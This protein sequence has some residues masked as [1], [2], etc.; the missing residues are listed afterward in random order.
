[1]KSGRITKLLALFLC[2][3]M[4]VSLL[5]I[6]S[7]AA[8]ED[9]VPE[10]GGEWTVGSV[11]DDGEEPYAVAAEDDTIL[12][13]ADWNELYPFGTFAFGNHQAD[14][15]EPGATTP[16]RCEIPQSL[17]IPVYR[18][19]G[20]V[21]RVTARIRF[22][23]AVTKDVNGEEDVFDYAASGSTD[24]LIEVE[25]PNPIA[26]YQPLGIPDA[27][28]NI[29]A[30]DL[31]VTLAEH[32]DVVLETDEIR[33]ILSEASQAD[34]Y[35]WQ[36]ND[37]S[38]W[39]D[40]TDAEEA[41]LPVLWSDLWDFETDEWTG[42]DFRCIYEKD[43]ALFSTTSLLGEVYESPYVD[44][45]PIPA[46]LVIPEERTYSALTFADEYDGCDFELTFADGETVKYIRVT[47]LDDEI[48]ELPEIGLFTITGC[49]GGTLTDTCNTL[50]LM[51]SD[52]DAK[53]P[54][55]LGFAAETVA[56]DRAEGVAR[57]KVVRTGGKSYTVT[58]HY[59]TENGTA[60]AGID[61]AATEGDLAFAG[62]IDEIEILVPLITNFE[63]EDKTFSLA[64]SDVRGGGTEK[65]CTL[66]TE[67]TEVTL[68]GSATETDDEGA[69][70]NLATVLTGDHG[71]DVS[72]RVNRSEDA[73]IQVEQEAEIL[74]SVVMPD[75]TVAEATLVLPQQTRLHQVPGY[76]KFTRQQILDVE[77]TMDHGAD[78]NYFWRDWDDILG[79]AHLAYGSGLDS[80]RS[81]TQPISW[82][83]D[84]DSGTSGINFEVGWG[85]RSYGTHSDIDSTG[86]QE[87]GGSGGGYMVTKVDTNYRGQV[88]SKWTD[89]YAPGDY[90]D[91]LLITFGWARPGVRTTSWIE[92]DCHRYLR[93]EIKVTVGNWSETQRLNVDTSTDKA[94]TIADSWQAYCRVKGYGNWEKDWASRYNHEYRYSSPEGPSLGFGDSFKIEFDFQFYNTWTH[95]LAKYYNKALTE[96]DMKQ[97]FD[98]RNVSGHRRVFGKTGS[99][100]IT[101]K[102]Y[103]AND[104]N[105]SVQNDYVQ[106]DETSELYSRLAPVLSIVPEQGGVD[107][108]GNIYVGTKLKID[109]TNIKA[110]FTIP[111]DG[112]FI[113]NENHQIVGKLEADSRQG[114]VWY[115]TMIWNGI[116]DSDLNKDYSLCVYYNRMQNIE[117][118]M[119]HAISP[120]STDVAGD[121]NRAWNAFLENTVT[122]HKTEITKVDGKLT[123][124]TVDQTWGPDQGASF[125]VDGA[126]YTLSNI[127]NIQTVCF[128]QDPDDV[129]VYDG[130]GYAGNAEIPLAKG[131][132]TSNTLLF[133]FYSSEFLNT[134][135]IMEIFI[136][137]VEVYYDQ[138]GDGVIRGTMSDDNMFILDVDD[139]GQPLDTFVGEV[140]GDYPDSYF[141]PVL[142]DQGV[143]HEHFFKVFLRMSPRSLGVPSGYTGD[144]KAQLL[145]AF[146]TAITDASE[147]A[148]LT[149]EQR[150]YRYIRGFDTD[151]LPMFGEAVYAM[152]TIDIPLG[153]DVGTI[154][155]DSVSNGIFNEDGELIDTNTVDVFTWEPDFRGNLL[156]SFDSPTPILDTRNATGGEVPL[157]GENPELNADGTFA[158][159]AEGLQ[160]LNG[161]LG[162]FTDRTT[163]AI[164]VQEQAKPSRSAD[165]ADAITGFSDLNPESMTIGEVRSI[166][167]ADNMTTLTSAGDPGETQGMSP[168]TSED[169]KDFKQDFGTKL[170]SLEFGIG[171]KATL[172]MDG[173][174]VG[175]AV[176]LPM[177]KNGSS[178]TFGG[179]TEETMADGAQKT[180]WTDG[181]GNL[182]EQYT[183]TTNNNEEVTATVVTANDPSDPT[184]RTKTITTETKGTDGKTHYR[185]E[186][187][188]Q[189][190]DANGN[191]V[192]TGKT[193]SDTKPQ[194]SRGEKFK[195]DTGIDTLESFCTACAT[196]DVGELSKF[197][198]GQMK[199]DTYNAAKNGRGA[200][201]NRSVSFTVQF[202]IMF[203]YNPIDDC[204][205]FKSAGL[206]GVLG[207]NFSL[208]MRFTP[209]PLAYLYMKVGVSFKL[210]L[211]L[212]CYRIA[213]YG[214]AIK[215]EDFV[216]GNYNTLAA[217]GGEAVFK[218]DMRD[219]YAKE[220]GF[221]FN[222]NGKVIME[223]YDNAALTG[224][225]LNSGALSGNGGN[226]ETLLKAYDKEVYIKLKQIN[227]AS[228]AEI[229]NIRPITG[230]DSKVRFNG[231]TLE[232]SLSIEVGIGLGIEV[233]KIEA[234]LRFNT[235]IAFTMGG[236]LEETDSYEG[237]YI[238]SFKGS[239]AIGLNI[240]LVFIDYTLDALAFGFE[241]KQHGTR[242]YF[243]WHISCTA[244]NGNEELWATDAYTS[245]DGHTLDGEPVPPNGINIFKDNPDIH[246]F[247]KNGDPVD[248]SDKAPTNQGW[249][250]RTGV[251]AWRWSGGDFLGEVPQN[252]DLAEADES[253]VFIKFTPE[254][255]KIKLYFSGS[256]QVF[257]GESDTT[258]T[259]YTS[260][261]AT[262]DNCDCEVKVVLKEGAKLDRYHLVDGT[263]IN[264]AVEGTRNVSRSLVHISESKDVSLSQTILTPEPDSRAITPTGTEDFELSGYNTTGDARR[265]VGGLTT[266]YDYLLV[267]AGEENYILYPYQ[268][269]GVPQLVLSKLVMTDSFAEGTG[270]VHPITGGTDPAYL[271]LD[272]DSCSDL[273]FDAVG[274]EDSIRVVWVTANSSGEAGYSVK[275]RDIPLTPDETLPATVTLSTG[276][277]P[278][279]LPAA[280][281]TGAVWV[282]ASG[283]GA[284]VNNLLKA[285]LRA[286]ND[287]MTDE[288]FEHPN[289]VSDPDI[290]VKA[291]QWATMSSL[292]AFNGDESVL[293]AR[294]GDTVIEDTITDEHVTNLETV[295][296]GDQ[297][298]I[299]YSTT[300]VVYFDTTQDVPV[301]VGPDGMDKAT[302][303]S[304]IHRLYLRKADED[305]FSDPVCIETVVDHDGCDQD[306]LDSARLKDGIYANG[307][308]K[309]AQADPYFANLRFVSAELN[310]TG[311]QTIAFFEM[312]GNTWLL[313]EADMNTLLSGGSGN[314]TITPVFSETT[315]TDVA[316]GSD[317]KNLAIVY[318]A[319]VDNSLSN[320]IFISWWDKNVESWGNPTI[321][322]MRGLQI[323]EDRI[324][325]DMTPEEA[326]K[327]YFGEIETEGGHTGSNKKLT[328]S[329]LQMSKATI[330]HD[331]KT[332]DQLII[333]TTGA[334]SEYMERTFHMSNGDDYTTKVPNPDVD[335]ALGFY[336]IGFG[337][338]EQAIGEGD[339]DF[340]EHDF[341][342]GSKLKGEVSFRNTGT[343]AIRA[344]DANPMTIRL[345]VTA[346]IENSPAQEIAQW[347]LSKSIPSGRQT[348]LYFEG[349]PL[350]HNLR[351]GAAFYLE[352]TEDG[353]FTENYQ[354]TIYD[355]FTLQSKPE[356]SFSTFDLKLTN[357]KNG[358]A[359]FALNAAVVNNGS[360]DA[361]D[362]FIQFSY[363]SGEV[364]TFGNRIYYPIDITG[365][366][367]ET[368]V[369]TPV[370]F[371]SVQDDFEN[372]IYHLCGS[373]G[374]RIDSG[375]YRTVTGD[376]CVPIECFVNKEDI[377]G[378]HI[379]A[380]IYC[381][382]DTPNYQYGVYGSDHADY[383]DLNN[384]HE[385][386]IK[387][388][389]LFSVPGQIAT[390]LGTTLIL[391]V[392]FEA[393]DSQPDLLLTEIS[394]G[395]PDWSPRM[396][397]CYYDPVRKV[398]VAAPNSTAQ[399]MLEA[400]RVP[401]GI[402]QL[403]DMSTNTIE[404]ITYRIDSMAQG[405]NI[406]RDDASFTFYDANGEATNLYTEASENTG[407][408]FLDKGVAVGWTG[409]EPG[410]IP[411]NHDLCLANQEGAFFTF[412]T[413]ADTMTF[414]FMGQITVE[415]SLF[416]TSTLTTSPA[417]IE[418]NNPTGAFHTL[419][420]TAKA[421]TKI[422]RYVATYQ[423]NPV[424]D[425][426]PD[427]PQVLWNRSFPDVAS[428]PE[429]SSVPMT[430]YII[431]KS[432]ILSVSFD[433]QPLSETTTPALVKL[434]DKLWY[435]DYT[436]TGNGLHKV[437]VTDIAGNSGESHVAAEWFNS[438]ISTGAN[439]DAPEFNRSHVKLTDPDGDQIEMNKPIN[440][441]PWLVSAYEPR[442]D[443]QS[444]VLPYTDGEFPDTPL[445]KDDG[446][447]WLIAEDGCYQLRV[448]REDGTWA[449]VIVSID[450]VDLI[451]PEL[452]AKFSVDEIKIMAVD[453]K[454]IASVTVNR[455]PLPTSGSA[456]MGI[457]PV[458]F[459][460]DYTVAVSDA[461]GN[462][463]KQVVHAE[464]PLTVKNVETE[465]LCPNGEIS[466]NVTVKRSDIVG[467]RF[468]EAYSVP[469]ENIYDARYEVVLA[470]E[471][472]TEAPTDGWTAVNDACTLTVGEGAYELF[473]RNSLGQIAKKETALRLY[474]PMSWGTPTYDWVETETGY[475]VTATSICELDAT[476]VTTETVEATGDVLYEA[477]CETDGSYIYTANFENALFTTQKKYVPIPA[478]GHEWGEPSYTWTPYE[479]GYF[480]D[481]VSTCLHDPT[482]HETE[483]VTATSTVTIPPLCESD[484]EMLYTATFET[485]L[486]T[487][488]TK[489]DP[490]PMLG[491]QW[492]TPTY[493]WVETETGYTVTGTTICEHD[494]TH[495]G[496]ETVEA[497]YE[498][499][500]SPTTKADG[501][502]RYTAVFLDARFTT[503]TKDI[504]LPMLQP[505]FY[506]E[507][508][509]AA[510]VAE[511]TDGRILY[512]YDV[513]VKNVDV[514]RLAVSMQIFVGYDPT[515][516]TFAE[517]RTM[518]EGTVSINVSDG[519]AGFAWATD[520]EPQ[521]LPDGTV[522]LSL[523][524]EAAGAIAD[525]TVAVFPFAE[526]GFRTG[527]AYLGA[528]GDI[529]EANPVLYEDGSIT[530]ETPDT[531]T[532]EGEDVIANDAWMIE[533]GE[534]LYR[535]DV[536]ISDLPDPGLSVN[537]AQIFL[538]YDGAKLSFRKAEGMV[539]WTATEKNGKLLCAWA[540]ESGVLMRNGDVVLTLWF[541]KGEGVRMGERVE[542]V[543]TENALGY[544]TS[545]SFEFSGKVTEVEAETV[546][547]SITFEAPLYGDANCDGMVTAADAALILRAVVGLSELSPRGAINADVDN[548]LAVTAADAA[549]IL[550]YVVGLIESLPVE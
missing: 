509:S 512:R 270:L 226:Q 149:D 18:F 281:S 70:Q 291:F 29:A 117:I 384:R 345:M 534:I 398:I 394:D 48:P 34:S 184:K 81:Y 500:A 198:S 133:A 17:L 74:G 372:G 155:L 58:V 393:T 115:C 535:Y 56:V 144:E 26:Q 73:L 19:G 435:F 145:P 38:G 143:L 169:T 480:V 488:Q 267:P 273:S 257:K 106:L 104:Q 209:F 440:Y 536:C 59:T 321:L 436:F 461:A 520:G 177:Y 79:A 224:N 148:K 264:P 338:G 286:K 524:F 337:M 330:D 336:A 138:D 287:K 305:G 128:H 492:G 139:D 275:Q 504:V 548:D 447:R 525:G 413:V 318:T 180:S 518:L 405:V 389:T 304:T 49:E 347:K 172:I 242:G 482:H 171:S 362:T 187:K 116:G 216:S 240:S 142:D 411:M 188:T 540:S 57:V 422:D 78:A 396:G 53:E 327:A 294:I 175:F 121:L 232:P 316:I 334:M 537:S 546:D 401:T 506:G 392:S 47:A 122:V 189:Q 204:H 238:S 425:P 444:K 252:S 129:I 208:Q 118:N 423:S 245:A 178:K 326:E 497:T 32:P 549:A 220:R 197:M 431:D 399:A 190:Q 194:L 446:E 426:D 88:R 356:L 50:T 453:N 31:F 315:G 174:K 221:V 276:D 487:Q 547:G 514:D 114:N 434:S 289:Q 207:L 526:E 225:P 193:V 259:T 90:Y 212:T 250:F 333:L 409:G 471:G 406:Y 352:L 297:V 28:K 159:S 418:F 490:I 414:Y 416:G 140:A 323:Y 402:L 474:H 96:S 43:G 439:A 521:A 475:T 112:V 123:F 206:S 508:V 296:V 310:E 237:F 161:Y 449:R 152:R 239:I 395:T 165:G 44:P 108:N 342:A 80:L 427:E 200:T 309:E 523:Y 483:R 176:S 23:P 102:I 467:G 410:E 348:T 513:L 234:F 195:K 5:P 460:G 493:D 290:A 228:P 156:V 408:S 479:D 183:Y 354:G 150:M 350:A 69:G 63:T 271:V 39:Q 298:Y 173:Y 468:D 505:T 473:V 278:C 355:L 450:G 527:F 498:L 68:F 417:T 72:D 254:K 366:N 249:T 380:E 538:A 146:V 203:E 263:A 455:Y 244:L 331:G 489:T 454:S 496:T 62:E 280:E 15:A 420:V 16:D 2:L 457:F 464:I 103:T 97:Q 265:L 343:A 404:A 472:T 531:L 550:R 130:R 283:D 113:E 101:L 306:T 137:R 463:T 231:A 375:Y 243:N 462:T 367:L 332:T 147:A 181:D 517:A 530:F 132:L 438:V 164:G 201:R 55:E 260:S 391:P 229:S 369:M 95:D 163:F 210:S 256:I 346:G 10:S 255:P 192:G 99:N 160:K 374:T 430:C 522:V 376:L 307:S 9:G 543:F 476:H 341:T 529:L 30:S 166:P 241:G 110:N 205:Y 357:V 233:L 528:D 92:S 125:S 313:T 419:K 222:I 344:S 308:L 236:Y 218:L 451:P 261:P 295:T 319:A 501:L 541:A 424:V 377:S 52:N 21:G 351:E 282:S 40:I 421:G 61:Y 437:G 67:R 77:A 109:C 325:Y 279:M 445:D 364:D 86:S 359:T 378:L 388:Q 299:L 85:R 136:D 269:D 349:N 311:A 503:Q 219:D 191:W 379:K 235:S 266:G 11:G 126:N 4:T 131:D 300:Q 93:P 293:H 251:L 458:S 328:F 105:S 8:E 363:D 412:N 292:N 35:R 443:E 477:T 157:A 407:W 452:L 544:P 185:Q 324:T 459:T 134:S 94:A 494:S 284:R 491:H 466:I 186:V 499:I 368:G 107:T 456:Y 390:A 3:C 433:D 20:T 428:L 1:M 277:D 465:V 415:S 84:P 381:S 179:E 13:G 196:R 66:S 400:G 41:E 64:L 442:S 202:A 247:K 153:G 151:N 370:R 312:G 12:P 329:N 339:L 36:A 365:S 353:Y 211:S 54:S 217:Q 495:I 533:N 361:E 83:V 403:K 317:G 532:I 119:S 429:G 199:D 484:G 27:E 253:G 258:G 386:T 65:L 22:M 507:H 14:V 37:R 320:A 322:A 25:D 91:Q 383:N 358:I 135:S 387:H 469:M 127:G 441:T 371:T 98:I 303:R 168:E 519:V 340:S 158:Y 385:K 82:T 76:Y 478:F 215:N 230:A 272:D 124:R 262:I 302:E 314:V 7:A 223:I 60:L 470:P 45:D 246:F 511:Y 6:R 154:R 182:N 486:F 162:S 448:D 268:I 502:E 288:V 33:L 71:R 141:A 42:M 46:D 335:T 545:V 301:T 539:D 167:N 373:D 213:K 120:D 485:E 51:I 382:A 510:D 285:W 432:G 248:I 75:P 397:V 100:G 274:A 542:I 24:L 227:G 214:D 170:P 360:E 111:Q 87:R 89:S 481:A 515:L 516:L